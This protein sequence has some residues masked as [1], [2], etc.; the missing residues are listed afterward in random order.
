MVV[1]LSG[2]ELR[3]VL[4]SPPPEGSPQAALRCKEGK[5]KTS[6]LQ[7]IKFDGEYYK[8]LQQAGKTSKGALL[9]RVQ[10]QRSTQQDRRLLWEF[11]RQVFLTVL[12]VLPWRIFKVLFSEQQSSNN[13]NH[14]SLLRLTW[15][16]PR[17]LMCKGVL[18]P[19]M[20]AR[21]M[22]DQRSTFCISTGIINSA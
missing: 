2:L 15:R 8:S 5:Q 3:H 13:S 6:R 11:G 21:S 10:K 20:H 18:E 16:R 7:S 1:L 4:R 14:F 22:T 9:P 12:P 17:C 19:A